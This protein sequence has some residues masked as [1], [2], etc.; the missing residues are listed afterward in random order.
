MAQ[1]TAGFAALSSGTSHLGL[2]PDY[3]PLL[4]ELQTIFRSGKTKN[5]E[6]RKAQLR[7]VRLQSKPTDASTWSSPNVAVTAFWQTAI[8]N[9]AKPAQTCAPTRARAATHLHPP[10]HPHMYNHLPAR[11]AHAWTSAR[12]HGQIVKIAQECHEEIAAAIQYPACVFMMCVYFFVFG[13]DHGGFKLPGL[14]EHVC[15]HLS[16]HACKHVYT[17]ADVCAHVYKHVY[18]HGHAH[19]HA[20]RHIHR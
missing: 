7:Q 13:A 1:T 17:H 3:S 12:V 15:R 2:E 14:G 20:H 9:T 8:Q 4:A 18:K 11:C 16:G 19:R 5:V 10:T 6:W